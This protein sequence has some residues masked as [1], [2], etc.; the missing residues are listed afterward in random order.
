MGHILVS[1]ITPSFNKSR[2]I[3]KTIQSVT[4]QE[5]P[6]IEHII[7]DG[8]STDGTREILARYANLTWVSEADRGQS[9]ALNKGFKMA[10]GEILGG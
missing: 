7:I 8:A 6:K 9:H 5:Y 4:A 10:K 3:A 1:I 2:F